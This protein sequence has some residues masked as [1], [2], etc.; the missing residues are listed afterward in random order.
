M[1]V[2]RLW[3]LA[4]EAEQVA[5]QTYHRLLDRH[6]NPEEF[7]K[8]RW[9]SRPRLRTIV[10]RVVD[11]G[12]P[13]GAHAVVTRDDGALLLVRHADVGKWVL[14]G[15]EVGQDESFVDAAAR[16]LRE[17]AGVEATF[18]GLALLGRVEF[19][20]DD[21]STWGALPI[22]RARAESTDLTVADPDE[23]IVDAMW[24]HSLP[25]DTRDREILRSWCRS[26]VW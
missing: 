18:D 13:Y 12:L 21:H 25:E 3:Y 14:P 22:Y 9:V 16:E 7:T 19:Y 11:N 20:G 26:T 5:A 6:G 23:E 2:D 1:T 17:E 10:E 4:D 15:G 24:V 8:S